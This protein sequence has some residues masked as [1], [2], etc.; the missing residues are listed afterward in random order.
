MEGKVS[1]S[2]WELTFLIPVL[3]IQPHYERND[4]LMRSNEYVRF[5]LAAIKHT[6]YNIPAISIHNRMKFKTKHKSQAWWFM[7][8]ILTFDII[9]Q[10]D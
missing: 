4:Y 5:I 10:E 8:I 6:T 9:K 7:C 2:T 3:A 1:T